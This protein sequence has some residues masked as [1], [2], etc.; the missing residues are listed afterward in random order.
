MTGIQELQ[1]E[2]LGLEAQLHGK[3]LELAMA[4]GERTLAQGHLQNMQ[5]VIL[6]RRDFRIACGTDNDGCFFV[7][8]GDADKAVGRVA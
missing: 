2:V 7:A 5:R 6:Q 8:A 3:R 1:D 4:M